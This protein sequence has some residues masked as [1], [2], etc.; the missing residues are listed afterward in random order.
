MFS[1]ESVLKS[2]NNNELVVNSNISPLPFS[3][4]CFS[5]FANTEKIVADNDDKIECFH[6]S[7]FNYP[8]TNT[9]PLSPMNNSLPKITI[10]KTNG[11][12]SKCKD[13][14]ACNIMQNGDCKNLSFKIVR[15]D[16]FPFMGF[17][18]KYKCSFCNKSYKRK[19]Y[20]K[21]HIYLDHSGYNGTICKFCGK[22]FKR[23]IDHLF[24]CKIKNNNNN[25]FM[26]NKEV[27]LRNTFEKNNSINN[28]ERLFSIDNIKSEIFI[29]LKEIKS[30]V[31]EEFNEYIYYCDY[32]IGFSEKIKKLEKM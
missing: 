25:N 16:S 29:S 24:L 7:I 14:N 1:F 9:F 8:E 20:L 12:L 30:Q 2:N 23:I 26:N 4:I 5:Y 28:N 10:K 22:K 6:T 17:T 19:D 13:I 3:N 21:K 11:N 31:F 32:V 27:Y 18:Q 15:T